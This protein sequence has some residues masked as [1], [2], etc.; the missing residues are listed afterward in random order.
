MGTTSELDVRHIARINP[1]HRLL[2]APGPTTVDPRILSAMA[3]PT[4]GQ[5]DPYMLKIMGEVQ[6]ML[7]YTF[8]APGYEAL[9]VDGSSRAA[10]DCAL[11]SVIA[12]GDRVLV[13]SAGRFGS[14]LREIATRLGAEVTQITKEWGSVFDL[15]KIEAAIKKVNPKLV[16]TVAGDTSTTML[17]PL[18]GLGQI[19]HAHGALLYTDATASFVGNDLRCA[20]PEL[21]QPAAILDFYGFWNL[22][23]TFL[24]EPSAH[25]Q[26]MP[27]VDVQTV[28]R[29]CGEEGALVLGGANAQRYSV[30]VYARQTGRWG[31]LLGVRTDAVRE[32]LSLDPE[33]VAALPP[34]FITASTGDQD[35]PLKQSKTLMRA[36][37]GAVMHQV[38]YL[39]HDFDRDVSNPAGREAYEAALAFLSDRLGR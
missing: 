39:E 31:A 8:K 7:R 36:A 19:C 11:V 9:M 38:Y 15:A 29:I 10:I 27:R 14:L 1:P 28:E 21:L 34:L 16:C 5:F 6:E 32:A 26:S 37:T 25:Y 3:M 20:A 30:Y 33:D 12:P 13:C 4:V 35:V 24:H 22:D 2:M 18:E 23:A 17:Q